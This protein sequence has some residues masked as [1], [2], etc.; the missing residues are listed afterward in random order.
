MFNQLNL[1]NL[2]IMDSVLN[3]KSLFSEHEKWEF[4]RYSLEQCEEAMQLIQKRIKL[5]TNPDYKTW[6]EKSIWDFPLSTRSRVILFNSG[7]KTAGDLLNY[8]IDRIEILKGCGQVS[9]K[10]IRDVVIKELPVS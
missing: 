7:I 3:T 10:E 2:D 9:A 8:G 1:I 6:L 5:L 4:S